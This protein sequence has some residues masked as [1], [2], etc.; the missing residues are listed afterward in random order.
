MS[1]PKTGDGLPAA[2]EIPV[3]A[4]QA[5]R[6]ERRQHVVALGVK[7]VIAVW[8]RVRGAVNL[9]RLPEGL[10]KQLT[11][12]A[13]G[14]PVLV[15]PDR[16]DLHG[17]GAT[18][19]HCQHL[20]TQVGREQNHRAE[21]DHCR[22]LFGEEL[23]E[24][25]VQR[26][27]RTLAESEND[28][29]LPLKVKLS[30]LGL[31]CLD[32]GA[33]KQFHVVE[34]VEVRVFEVLAVAQVE[35]SI[36]HLWG[37]QVKLGVGLASWV[38]CPGQDHHAG[39]A[40]GCW[41]VLEHFLFSLRIVADPNEQGRR[42]LHVSGLLAD[43]HGALRAH[44]CHALTGEEEVEPLALELVALFRL[45]LLRQLRFLR[46]GKL[47]LLGLLLLRRVLQLFRKRWEDEDHLRVIR[48]IRCPGEGIADC[49]LTNLVEHRLDCEL[50]GTDEPCD[51][52][53]D[54]HHLLRVCGQCMHPPGYVEAKNLPAPRGQQRRRE[55]QRLRNAVPVD[56]DRG[57]LV[58]GLQAVDQLLAGVARSNAI[59]SQL[60]QHTLIAVPPP[61]QSDG[62][63]EDLFGPHRDEPL[64]DALVLGSHC[65][66][67]HG[68]V[69]GILP[70]ALG[71]VLTPHRILRRPGQRQ[72]AQGLQLQQLTELQ[73]GAARCRQVGRIHQHGVA[74]LELGPEDLQHHIGSDD[75][76]SEA[77]LLGGQLL[78]D[79]VRDPRDILLVA[80]QKRPGC[81]DWPFRREL[82][83][84]GHHQDGILRLELLDTCAHLLDAADADHAQADTAPLQL[85]VDHGVVHRHGEHA[86]EDLIVVDGLLQRLRL[87]LDLHLTAQRL[88]VG[89]GLGRAKHVLHRACVVD[90]R[91]KLSSIEEVRLHEILVCQHH[92]SLIPL[93][94]PLRKALLVRL[95]TGDDPVLQAHEGPVI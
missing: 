42:I 20:V 49:V 17:C 47:L 33:A 28:N 94:Q 43:R 19:L 16:E 26:N 21:E 90:L 61:E 79:L 88:A 24:G 72:H 62:I 11:V 23:E 83:R 86:D 12:G 87:C 52:I 37:L 69:V 44:S 75:R 31:D 45:L 95:G 80:R 81:T 77:N 59:K 93:P 3:L 36:D 57:F 85:S 14:G 15:A 1:N 78:Q 64:A 53:H 70:S 91:G 82:G 4:R 29:V 68:S 67:G 5:E 10:G 84:L 73:Q 13:R 66:R 89:I 63:G 54:G 39:A 71:A 22:H 60:G 9:G 46:Q 32:N 2:K 18:L 76:R 40:K 65:G 8:Q 48:C 7:A 74:R 55:L 30:Q 92:G 6:Q 50:V 34:H 58:A 35:G 41:Q 56:N 25:C 38:S 51:V 27:A